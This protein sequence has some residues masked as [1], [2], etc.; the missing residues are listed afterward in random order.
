[1]NVDAD[2]V[3]FLIIAS[4]EIVSCESRSF[5]SERFERDD[6]DSWAVMQKSVERVYIVYSEWYWF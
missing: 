3:V 1:M 6:D 2:V 4:Y 5:W